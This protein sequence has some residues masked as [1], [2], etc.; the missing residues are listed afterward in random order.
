MFHLFS[1]IDFILLVLIQIK[2]SAASTDFMRDILF[3]LWRNFHPTKLSHANKMVKLWKGFKFV[4]SDTGF[5][6]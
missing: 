2:T 5:E 6:R 1:N 3:G 4:P